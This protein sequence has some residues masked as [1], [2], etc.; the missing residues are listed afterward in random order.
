M[1]KQRGRGKDE[2]FD[3]SQASCL[4]QQID[5]CGDLPLEETL[6]LLRCNSPKCAG[7]CKNPKKD[8]PNCLCGLLPNPGSY[9]KKGLWQKQPSVINELGA[10]P[11][12]SKRQ[13]GFSSSPS[14]NNS[15]GSVPLTPSD[16][17]AVCIY[18]HMHIIIAVLG[19][20]VCH[21]ANL[22]V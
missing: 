16:T 22:H 9:R 10:D 15:S 2:A 4:L 19:S 8:N 17:V 11:A 5:V 20:L 13:V 1:P 18:Q 12:E 21:A 6:Q 7:T 3:A 14:N